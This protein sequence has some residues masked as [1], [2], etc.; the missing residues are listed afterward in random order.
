MRERRLCD[1]RE[2]RNF[3]LL[4][5]EVAPGHLVTVDVGELKQKH[6]QHVPRIRGV[7]AVV[8]S[9]GEGGAGGVGDGVEG[10]V[11]R[12]CRERPVGRGLVAEILW[13]QRVASMGNPGIASCVAPRACVPL[14]I[15]WAAALSP[16]HKIS[17]GCDDR[18][19]TDSVYTAST[20]LQST[21]FGVPA[22]TPA[23]DA[24]RGRRAAMLR[25][26]EGRL[27]HVGE[28]GEDIRESE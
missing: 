12:V 24:V 16:P 8:W 23:K 2:C 4:K 14:S 18:T 19:T 27:L 21:A 11:E 28:V 3:Y 9:A 6:L 10:L 20:Y 25:M 26:S 13:R 17:T 22:T 1:A 7:F 15:W 5:L